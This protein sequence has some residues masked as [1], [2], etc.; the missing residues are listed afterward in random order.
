MKRKRQKKINYFFWIF[1]TLILVASGFMIRKFFFDSFENFPA[2]L[3][4]PA[5][6]RAMVKLSGDDVFREI[7]EIEILENDTVL[8]DNGNEI[9]LEIFDNSKIFLTKNSEIIL[10]KMRQWSN[11]KTEISAKVVRGDIWFSVKRKVNP[12]SSFVVS[13]GELNLQTLGGEFLIRNNFVAAVSGSAKIFHKE[14]FLENLQLGQ[15]IDFSKN[16]NGEFLAKK[17]IISPEIQSWDWFTIRSKNFEL[18]SFP[19]NLND[20]NKTEQNVTDIESL[21]KGKIEILT[22]GKNDEEVIVDDPVVISG[23]VPVGTQKVLVNDYQLSKFSPGDTEFKYNAA[24]EWKTLQPGKNEYDVVAVLKNNEKVIAKIILI[25]EPE[26]LESENFSRSESLE[27]KILENSKKCQIISPQNNE[28]F[29]Q[30][31]V[32]INGSASEITSSIIV[33]NWKLQKYSPGDATWTYRL[34]DKYGNRQVGKREIVV[35]CFDINEKLIGEDE[36]EI[37]ILEISEN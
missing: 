7:S 25:F 18:S 1:L 21:E 14:S 3:N 22:P 8:A 29:D 33:D 36:I 11:N 23:K 28:S 16:S 13:F 27:N 9:F 4:I 2:K 31:V 19:E 20:E 5:G 26:Q 15:Q 24:T 6:N 35:K 10:E 30:D 32:E 12:A 37:E 17:E 34:A